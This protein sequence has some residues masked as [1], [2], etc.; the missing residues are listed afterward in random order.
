M[1]GVSQAYFIPQRGLDMFAAGR[2]RGLPR[3]DN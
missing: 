2:E 3:A 1:L